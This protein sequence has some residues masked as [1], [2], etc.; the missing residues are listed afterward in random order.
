MGTVTVS[1]QCHLR[2]NRDHH[3]TISPALNS[4]RSR[5]K[6]KPTFV[7]Y[8]SNLSYLQWLIKTPVHRCPSRNKTTSRERE[9]QLFLHPVHGII[10]VPLLDQIPAFCFAIA[11]L[12]EA[13]VHTLTHFIWLARILSAEGCSI[14]FCKDSLWKGLISQ[15]T[16]CP[17]CQQ[18]VPIQVGHKRT[19]ENIAVSGMS[20]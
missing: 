10:A 19:E 18:M 20:I 14:L 8:Q 9:W 6:C 16:W 4:S 3:F 11:C 2:R 15:T 17:Q 12:W 1:Q 5:S 13:A 7:I